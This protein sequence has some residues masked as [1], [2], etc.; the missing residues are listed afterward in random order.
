MVVAH[1]FASIETESL[2][3]K[4]TKQMKR[5]RAHIRA[6]DTALE[7]RPKALKAIRVYAANPRT[8]ICVEDIIALLGRSGRPYLSTASL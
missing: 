7:K 6:T 2:L 5:F 1:V 4:V 8:N 3:I